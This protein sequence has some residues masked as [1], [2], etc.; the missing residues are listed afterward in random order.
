MQIIKQ[1]YEILGETPTG[2]LETIKRIEL[3]GRTCY[4]SEDKI[5]DGSD[6]VFVNNIVKRKHMSVIEQSNFVLRARISMDLVS[7][8]KVMLIGIIDS[9][10]I[11]VIYHED[12]LYVGGNCRAFME[13]CNIPTLKDLF[14]HWYDLLFFV[15]SVP[16]KF[17]KVENVNDIPRALKRVSV[18]FRTD[19]AVLAEMTRHRPDIVFSV[20]S[21]RYCAYQDE[22]ILVIPHHYLSKFDMFINRTLPIS[23]NESIWYDHMLSVE[24]LY[25]YLLSEDLDKMKRKHSYKEKAEEARSC[26]PNS[27]ATD[28]FTTANLTEWDHMINLRTTPAAYKQYQILLTPMKDE[29]IQ[30]G[31]Y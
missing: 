21:Q 26:L 29:F 11:K 10:Y 8:Y 28:I 7:D 24:T 23:S 18:K 27:T 2:Y 31:W 3:A 22:L 5:V 17:E 19:R 6:E 13:R 12:Y 9:K 15:H 14:D 30:R 16:L 1:S 4:R 20:E 25:K